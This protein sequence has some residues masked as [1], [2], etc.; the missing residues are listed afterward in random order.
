MRAQQ[1]HCLSVELKAV[2]SSTDELARIAMEVRVLPTVIAKKG[3]SVLML[4]LYRW[5]P[6]TYMAE[7]TIIDGRALASKGEKR[8][9][10]NRISR[11]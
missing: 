9:S 3:W 4:V 8:L 1:C 11:L 10:A 5:Y 6:S 2:L 7:A